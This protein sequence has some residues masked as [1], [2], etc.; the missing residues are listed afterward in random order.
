MGLAAIIFIFWDNRHVV[1][2][3]LYGVITA[4]II[5]KN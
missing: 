4:Y 3:F 1:S 5:K 2:S